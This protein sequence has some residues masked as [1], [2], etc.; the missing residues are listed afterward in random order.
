MY[1][2]EVPSSGI[3]KWQVTAKV[4]REI[5]AFQFAPVLVDAWSDKTW[6]TSVILIRLGGGLR[7]DVIIG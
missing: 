1:S 4:I 3:N 6:T 2:A 7:W 5:F